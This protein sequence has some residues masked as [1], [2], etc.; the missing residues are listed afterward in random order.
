MARRFV[1]LR[2]GVLVL[3]I[4]PGRGLVC[5]DGKPSEYISISYGKESLEVQPARHR[6]KGESL[7]SHGKRSRLA[8]EAEPGKSRRRVPLYQRK[9]RGAD[10]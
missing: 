4:S 8:E 10:L 2:N 1:N 6:R 5:V 9:K 3:E 7:D